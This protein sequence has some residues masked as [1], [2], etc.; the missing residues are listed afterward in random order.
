MFYY[1]PIGIQNNDY[2]Q[3]LLPYKSTLCQY[4]I[5]CQIETTSDCQTYRKQNGE[6][7]YQHMLN[8]LRQKLIQSYI[9]TEIK[10]DKNENNY[11]KTNSFLFNKKKIRFYFNK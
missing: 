7:V 9:K 2:Y 6:Q 5:E 4:T 11:F 8:T 1:F 10:N 3:S